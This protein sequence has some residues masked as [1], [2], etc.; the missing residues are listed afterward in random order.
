[1]PRETFTLQ[2]GWL[3]IRLCLKVLSPLT[4]MNNMSQKY[5]YC[6]YEKLV[7]IKKEKTNV[8]GYDVFV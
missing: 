4:S 5:A 3:R 1:M 7:F 8:C 2:Q 6:Y